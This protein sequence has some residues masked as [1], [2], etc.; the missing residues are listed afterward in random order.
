MIDEIKDSEDIEP[1]VE[2][3]IDEI[4]NNVSLKS[5]D[6]E[7]P[8]S[9]KT[10]K[11]EV[12]VI[13]HGVVEKGPVME[14][15]DLTNEL[16]KEFA[17]F[18]E[19]KADI[20]QDKGIK[21]TVST[22][23][24]LVDAILGGGFA[25][26]GLNIIVGQPGSGKTMLAIQTLGQSQRQYGGKLIGGFL[27]SE[28]ATTTLRLSNLGVR[29]PKLRPYVDIT[30]EKVFKFIEG[31]CVFKEQKKIIEIPSVVVWDSIANTLSQ[32]ERETDDPNTVI[33]YKARL[34][35]ILVPKYVAKCAQHNICLLAVN[36]LR[37]VLSIGQ[38]AP[39][40]DLKF[41]SATKDMPGGNVLKFNAF[42]LV[43]M[44]VKT[45][46]TSKSA[47]KSDNYGFEGIIVTIK[48]V[49]N[50]LFPPNVEVP[51]VGSF[52]TGFSNFWTNYNFL[53]ET[54]RLNAGAWNYLVSLPDKKFRT[55]DAP[56]L[57]KTDVDFQKA[58]DAAV[59]EAIRTEIIDKYNPEVD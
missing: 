46:I 33:G 3:N 10:N 30:V 32:K 36:Q 9:T 43:E 21:V 22:G 4:M 58:Y 53:K 28:E 24:D 48:C 18:L 31:L 17:S 47:E 12:E 39:P 25:V 8:D 14:D 7:Q 20:V 23:I 51:L 11:V 49:K 38:F 37:D 15:E 41:M 6:K 16:Y 2:V 44:K 35:S 50:K 34:L 26:G 55:K 59:K 57:Y 40:K 45:A 29:Y 27:D 56:N 52:T 5:E 1:Q 13:D 54:K 19:N 42:Q